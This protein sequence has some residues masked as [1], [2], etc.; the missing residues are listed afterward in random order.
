MERGEITKDTYIAER[1]KAV[2]LSPTVNKKYIPITE[3]Q[4]NNQFLKE[5]GLI[6]ILEKQKSK[7]FLLGSI[8]NCH[9]FKYYR[10]LF[11]SIPS[12]SR[13]DTYRCKTMTE[14]TFRINALYLQ[15]ITYSNT[16]ISGIVLLNDA[17]DAKN[18]RLLI[19]SIN[20][21]R[22]SPTNNETNKNKYLRTF[23]KKRQRIT[24]KYLND[25]NLKL[26]G[27]ILIPFSEKG[28]YF[29][30]ISPFKHHMLSIFKSN[31]L[32]HSL[33]DAIPYHYKIFDI[34]NRIVPI[35]HIFPEYVTLYNELRYL[36]YIK[37]R[38]D[39]NKNNENRFLNFY[40]NE[41]CPNYIF[42]SNK[43]PSYI[44]SK[45]ANF[46]LCDINRIKKRNIR[47]G[48]NIGHQRDEIQISFIPKSNVYIP[49][50]MRKR[51]VILESKSDD[52]YFM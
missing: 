19:G 51:Y 27:I 13:P 10:N 49:P 1:L 11:Y 33:S 21:S 5:S 47:N 34:H 20:A 45:Y 8:E 41:K 30:R 25:N 18:N 4:K 22:N 3:K 40:F 36:S 42:I 7:I 31:K 12:H 44:L 28:D 43:E 37:E 35:G 29:S 46:N 6:P 50:P 52:T 39:N 48:R 38:F 9:K 26:V 16:D 14:F 23:H 2:V 17:N 32:E 15:I 24:K